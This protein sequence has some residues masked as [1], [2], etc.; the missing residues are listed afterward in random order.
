[1]KNYWEAESGTNY[2]Y[3]INL[4]VELLLDDDFFRWILAVCSSTLTFSNSNFVFP[5]SRDLFVSYYL[6]LIVI[7]R[8]KQKYY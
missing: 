1:M 3:F 8:I 7:D 4:F 5:F 2:L 6:N